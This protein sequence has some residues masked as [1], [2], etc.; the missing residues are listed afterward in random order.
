MYCGYTLYYGFMKIKA[1]PTL[2][3]AKTHSLKKDGAYNL[4][5]SDGKC[6]KS[7]QVLHGEYYGN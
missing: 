5:S 3:D 2:E 1:F 6:I 4:V 7:W